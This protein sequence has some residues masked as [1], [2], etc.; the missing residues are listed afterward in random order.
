M[1]LIGKAQTLQ[2]VTQSAYM[3]IAQCQD[4][5]KNCLAQLQGISASDAA[6]SI[7]AVLDAMAA[8]A[9]VVMDKTLALNEADHLNV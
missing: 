1:G 5:L 8:P 2:G 9:A 7:K 4:G 3:Q 6:A